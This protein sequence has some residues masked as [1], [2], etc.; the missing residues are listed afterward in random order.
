MKY[1]FLDT[2]IYIPKKNVFCG[3]DDTR[4]TLTQ[5]YFHCGPFRIKLKF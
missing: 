2:S 5:L 4:K 1:P 3:W